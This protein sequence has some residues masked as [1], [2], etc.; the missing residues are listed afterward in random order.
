V[1]PAGD[2]AA[3]LDAERQARLRETCRKLL[4]DAPFELTARAWAARGHV[5]GG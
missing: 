1:G 2:Y 4:P 3:G 5:R